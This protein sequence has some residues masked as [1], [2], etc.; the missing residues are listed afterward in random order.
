MPGRAREL[1]GGQFG[2]ATAGAIRLAAGR[3][4]TRVG[5]A[6]AERANPIRIRRV[7]GW[8]ARALG[9]DDDGR[10]AAARHAYPPSS[11]DLFRAAQGQLKLPHDAD[12]L[13]TSPRS[14]N[15]D[16]PFPTGDRIPQFERPK[17]SD[18]ADATLNVLSKDSL[19]TRRR[20]PFPIGVAVETPLPAKWYTS[21]GEIR[22]RYGWQ[23]SVRAASSPARSWRR[24]KKKLFVN[25]I[26]WLLGRDERLPVRR[27]RVELSASQRCD[28][29]GFG[30]ESC[31]VWGVRWACPF[32][33]ASLA[34]WSVVPALALRS[35]Q[36]SAISDQPNSLDWQ[37]AEFL[38]FVANQQSG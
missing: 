21:S 2:A 12:F 1:G 20:G 15:E 13:M 9:K 22:P 30:D 34:S 16:Q 32:C 35:S 17:T 36:R 33:S 38:R 6:A 4:P 37:T 14:W 29:P 25:T 10:T 18:K 23:L 11:A 28:P 26:N 19:E 8:T 31:G 5:F 7:C 27:P 24:P 3:R